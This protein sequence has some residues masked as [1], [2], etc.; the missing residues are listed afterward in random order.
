[1]VPT[2]CHLIANTM[3]LDDKSAEMEQDSSPIPR[4]ERISVN[5]SDLDSTSDGRKPQPRTP[6]TR[7]PTL[8]V[9]V[10]LHGQISKELEA[11]RVYA[12]ALGS[13]YDDDRFPGHIPMIL[14]NEE[15]EDVSSIVLAC[16]YIDAVFE[17]S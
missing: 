2:N 6:Y 8:Q 16:N 15:E 5:H 10:D 12:L 14:E 13:S 1:M 11:L 7:K 9:E 4:V 17:L 3:I